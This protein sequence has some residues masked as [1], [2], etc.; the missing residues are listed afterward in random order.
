MKRLFAR[1]RDANPGKV[2]GP[3]GDS[4]E[5]EARLHRLLGTGAPPDE[6]TPPGIAAEHR[7]LVR[8]ACEIPEAV[9][10]FNVIH[11]DFSDAEDPALRANAGWSVYRSAGGRSRLVLRSQS[12]E[13]VAAFLRRYVT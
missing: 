4:S 2:G 5:H 3:I 8:I 11:G 6:T 12:T 7:D 13:D 1:R 9:G 10:I